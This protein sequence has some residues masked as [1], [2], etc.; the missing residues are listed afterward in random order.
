MTQ[1]QQRSYNNNTKEKKSNDINTSGRQ[2]YN[3]DGQHKSTLELS[4]WNKMVSIKIYPMLPPDK[5]TDTE[6]FDYNGG[7]FTSMSSERAHHIAELITETIV[8]ALENGETVSAKGY[9]IGADSALVVGAKEDNN[10]IPYGYIAILRKIDRNTMIPAEGLVYQFNKT[11]LIDS[12]DFE[13]GDFNPGTSTTLELKDFAAQLKFAAE[14]LIGSTSHADRHVDNYYRSRIQEAVGIQS[15]GGSSGAPYNNSSVFN[16]RYSNRQ[17][18]PEENKQ[19]TIENVD[20]IDKM[21]N[22]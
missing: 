15:K 19:R 10:G 4:F 14:V 21:V 18:E 1:Y 5:V 22:M 7:I 2:Y 3:S 20:D 12:Y 8:P 9:P 6:K 16:E 13:S 11:L 17:T